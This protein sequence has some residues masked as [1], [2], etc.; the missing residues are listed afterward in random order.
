MSSITRPIGEIFKF[1]DTYLKVIKDGA[2]VGPSHPHRQRRS[3]GILTY[4]D[5]ED[6]TGRLHLPVPH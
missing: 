2:C 3:P 1:E 6:Q 4:P 5:T